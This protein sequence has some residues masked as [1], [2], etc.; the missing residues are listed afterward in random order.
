MERLQLLAEEREHFNREIHDGLGGYLSSA[1][2]IAER[3]SGTESTL[4]ETLRDATEEMRLMLDTAELGEGSIGFII[5]THRQKLQRQCEAKGFSFE[6]QI[7]DTVPTEHIGPSGA[8]SIIRIVQET[9]TNAL[10]HSNGNRICISVY[11]CQA[12]LRLEIADNGVCNTLSRLD[13]QGINNIRKRATEI[14]AL[15]EFEPNS[16][17]GGLLVVL[18]LPLRNVDSNNVQSL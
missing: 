3:V 2:S 18:L 7:N 8:L 13:G 10:R 6:W 14:G 17:L 4:T 12:T 5:G 11:E 15:V 16:A 9:V 1:L